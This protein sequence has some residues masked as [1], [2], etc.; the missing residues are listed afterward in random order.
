MEGKLVMNGLGFALVKDASIKSLPSD[1]VL[2]FKG[3]RS[4]SSKIFAQCLTVLIG[5]HYG[6][7]RSKYLKM[8]VLKELY[9][10]TS[11][12]DAANG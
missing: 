3:Q 10:Y 7:L 5:P 2:L 1:T 11:G 4:S 9:H 6:L 12:R 8:P